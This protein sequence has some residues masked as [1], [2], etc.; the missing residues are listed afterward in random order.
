M[1]GEKRVLG[2]CV[3]KIQDV[4]RSEFLSRLYAEAHQKQ[5]QVIVY[6]SFLDFR[7]QDAFDQGA[8][9]VY[10]LIDFR[11]LDVLVVLADAFIDV[12]MVQQLVDQA[13]DNNVPAVVLNGRAEG[14]CCIEED[15]YSAF[16]GMVSHV[17]QKHGAKEFWFAAGVADEWNQLLLQWFREALAEN[18]LPFAEDQARFDYS[19]PVTARQVLQDALSSGRKPPQAIVCAND[20][21]AFAVCD[22]LSECGYRVPEDVIVTGFGGVPSAAH[23]SPKLT[24]CDQNQAGFVS[25]LMDTVEEIFSGNAQDKRNACLVRYSESCG[26]QPADEED[27]HATICHLHRALAE[28]DVH[29]DIMYSW[30]DRVLG[31]EDMTGLYPALSSCILDDSFVCLNADAFQ[32]EQEQGDLAKREHGDELMVIPS[33]NLVG[34]AG[35]TKHIKRNAIIPELSAGQQ[36]DCLYV[37]NAIY[38]G[39]DAC[40]CYVVKTNDLLSC[41][42]KIKRVLKTLNIAVNAALNDCRQRNMRIG[43]ENAMLTDPISGLPNV[44]AAQQ[45]FEAFSQQDENRR[46]TMAISVYGIPKYSYIYEHYGIQDVEELITFIGDALRASM[47]EGSYIAHIADNEFVVIDHASAQG[48]MEEL[49]QQASAKFFSKITSFNEQSRK[50]YSLEVNHGYSIIDP[51]W[52]GS[53]ESFVKYAVGEMYLNRMRSGEMRVVKEQHSA[54]DYYSAFNLLVEKNLFT[55]HFQPIVDARTGNVYAYEAL[56]R[57]SGGINMSPLDVLDIARKYG[58]LY[59]IEKATLFNVMRCYVERY[60]EFGGHLLFINTIPGHFLNEEDCNLLMEMY[61]EYMDHVVFELTEQNTI[62]DHELQAIRRLQKDGEPVQIA[63]DDYGTGHSNIVNLLRYAPQV[64]KIDRYLISEIQNDTNKQMFVKNTIEFARLNGIMTLAEG[65]ET[66]DELQT[67]IEYGMD[68]VQGYYLGRPIANPV[69]AIQDQ[70]KNEIV[71]KNIRLSKLDSDMRAYTANDGEEINLLNL[72]INKFAFIDVF[73]G[74]V[75]L[76]GERDHTV[77][78]VIRVADNVK[79]TL[80]F[81]NANFKG[82]TE[83]TVQIGSGCQVTVVL[84]G[85]NTLHKEGILVPP[86]SSLHVVGDGNLNIL[87]SRNDGVGIGANYNSPYGSLTFDLTGKISIDASGDKV[88]GIGGGKMVKECIRMINGIFEVEAK[89]I[90]VVGVGSASGNADIRVE[91]AHLKVHCAGDEAVSIGSISGRVKLKST[92]IIEAIT[93]S[94]RAVGIGSLSGRESELH[95]T[96]GKVKAT[97]HCLISTCIGSFEG[98]IAIYCTGAVVDVYGEGSTI[99]GI[100][101]L[102]GRSQTIVSGGSLSIGF[103]AGTVLTCGNDQ[104]QLTINGGNVLAEGLEINAKN[105]FGMPLHPVLVEGDSFEKQI[106]TE[107]GSYIYR[108]KR[109]EEHSQLCVYLPEEE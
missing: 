58:R 28:M 82:A 103:L 101:S 46:H 59:E 79:A 15:A 77:D 78:M 39:K 21:I 83:T 89:G 62:S 27:I 95:F 55:Y 34:V 19:S 5:Y 67:V 1:L 87:A 88:V 48:G 107:L 75:T 65:V 36:K 7:H 92:G 32:T 33:A 16:K 13:R 10:G 43:L 68:L 6:N 66:F 100:G 3:T 63:V 96:R 74:V 104:C 52:S 24:T 71:S 86:T 56:M 11:I 108:A 47:P 72:A 25:L 73:G 60:E 4:A 91:N 81:R 2:V 41:N 42:Q 50:A 14:A 45:W 29:E 9:S 69:V 26:C 38:A 98:S 84:E 106:D 109:D 20:Y 94:E 80:I 99:T 31:M 97:N 105:L 93:D 17:T 35:E 70:I 23:F 90:N 76:V 85:E 53:L 51:G 12:S 102:K 18:G 30:I 44:K 22:A 8:M 54:E 49:I 37:V 64:I 57:T 40:G 61:G